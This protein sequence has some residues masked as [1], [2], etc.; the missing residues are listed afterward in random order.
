MDHLSFTLRGGAITT[1]IPAAPF[2]RLFQQ[3]LLRIPATA[4]M[5]VA[6][7]YLMEPVAIGL[8][9]WQWAGQGI[10]LMNYGAWFVVSLVFASV[11]YLGR[12]RID[13]PVADYLLLFMAV[14]FGILNF[15]I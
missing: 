13:N 10:P 1:L 7:D 3:A 5:M 2:L 12:V 6:F 11:L 14:F 15:T 9:M 8:D 4:L